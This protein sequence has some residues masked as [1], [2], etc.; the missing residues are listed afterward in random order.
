MILNIA[1]RQQY[2]IL[3]EQNYSKITT[4]NANRKLLQ[5][6]QMQILTLQTTILKEL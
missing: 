4:A 3:T 5:G 2:K 1:T 6:A